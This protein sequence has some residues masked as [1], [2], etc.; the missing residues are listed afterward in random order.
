MFLFHFCQDFL[1]V[2]KN[3]LWQKWNQVSFLQTEQKNSNFH[4]VLLYDCV[5]GQAVNVGVT[6]YVL[7][8]SSLSEVEMVLYMGL[9]I[10]IIII[11]FCFSLTV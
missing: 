8:I 4:R 5:S 10:H 11:S 1:F 9:I 3:M 2:E 6:M 7:S